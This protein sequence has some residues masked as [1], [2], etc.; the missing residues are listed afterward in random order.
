MLQETTIYHSS[1]FVPFL[2]I[3]GGGGEEHYCHNC[4]LYGDTLDLY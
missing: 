2:M 3:L 4:P 1:V